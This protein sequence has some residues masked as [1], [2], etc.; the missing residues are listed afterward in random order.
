MATP[1]RVLACGLATVDV[2]QAVE[3][4]PGANEKVVALGTRVEAGGP[5]LNA[6]V[7]AALLGMPCRLVTGVG[8]SPL[9]AVVRHDC[10]EHGVELVDVAGQ[11]FEL[12]VSTVLVTASSGERAVASRNAAGA[13]GWALPARGDLEEL[14]GGVS[15]VLVDGHHLP[16]ARVVAAAAREHGIP[17]VA[18]AGS[19]KPGLDGL[20][21]DVDVLVAS[22][23][24]RPP[25]GG[26][27]D[28]LLALGPTWVAR[29]AGA[30]PVRWLAA[31]GSS[32]TVDVPVVDVVDTLGAGD[33]LHGALLAEVGRHGM[34]DLPV[35]L[36]RA[37][38][39]AARSVTVAGVRGWATA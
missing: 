31:D 4:M 28:E 33:V 20:L 10:A 12:P 9:G 5:A 18:D 23:D 17:V 26:G 32:G 2:V 14:L 25:S 29:S 37:V 1:P 7:T 21:G 6:A 3:R 8:A 11:G 35:A 16:V 22:A 19:W 24:L 30:D 13:S 34:R 27:L 36:A 15:A 39:V 38:G